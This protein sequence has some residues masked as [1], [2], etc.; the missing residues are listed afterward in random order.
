MAAVALAARQQHHLEE[1]RRGKGDV[2]KNTDKHFLL[3]FRL[4]KGSKRMFGLCVCVCDGL[5]ILSASALHLQN[6]R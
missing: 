5:E 3:T 1:R 4:F 2:M 6:E